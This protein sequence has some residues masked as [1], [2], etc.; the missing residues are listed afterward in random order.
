MVL[1]TVVRLLRESIEAPE[2]MELMILPLPKGMQ[3]ES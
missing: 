3:G 1:M 2:A